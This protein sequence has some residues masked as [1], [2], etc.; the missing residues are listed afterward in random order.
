MATKQVSGGDFINSTT[1]DIR[2]DETFFLN[3]YVSFGSLASESWNTIT[4][5]DSLSS[6][7]LNWKSSQGSAISY[8]T[9]TTG[10]DTAGGDGGSVSISGKPEGLKASAT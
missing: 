6:Y 3:S 5:D 8:K 9:K 4:L 7:S 2:S 10:T 1:S